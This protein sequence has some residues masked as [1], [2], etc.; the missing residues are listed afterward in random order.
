MMGEA[1]NF[2]L[3]LISVTLEAK[4]V[5]KRASSIAES[6]PPMTAI[7]LPEAKKPS[8]VAQEETP[9]PMR[10]C[11]PG[12]DGLFA[13]VEGEGTLGEVDRVEM[14][15]AQLRT[16][17]GGLLLHVLNEFGAL[18]ALG[19]AGKVFHQRGNGELAA[20]LVAFEDERLEIGAC[21][22]D[23]GGKSGATGTEDDSVSRRV[24]GHIGS[25]SVNARRRKRMQTS[26]QVQIWLW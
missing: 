4:R 22:V 19:P 3:R 5:R 21:S 20:G 24:F 10:A 25:H 8:Q 6:P 7:S 12:V 26:L 1:R 13:D 9:W 18:N 14:R 11:S 16:E 23:G 15:H 17:A 2:S